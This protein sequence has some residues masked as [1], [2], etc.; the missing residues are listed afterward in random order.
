MQ[1]QSTL[2]TLKSAGF[3]LIA[4]ASLV[5]AISVVI[6]W[7]HG[8]SKFVWYGVRVYD[9]SGS[10]SY[11]SPHIVA[12]AVALIA[13]S[14]WVWGALRLLHGRRLAAAAER[15][16]C[17]VCGYDLRATPERCPECGYVPAAVATTNTGTR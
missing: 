4:A 14:L 13:P 16:V 2:V 6:S 9:G 5:L 7:T 11:E 15:Q 17:S 12:L 3:T 8:Q 10:F 1:R